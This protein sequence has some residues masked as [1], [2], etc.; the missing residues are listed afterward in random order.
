MPRPAHFGLVA[1]I[2]S[3]SATQFI[4][5]PPNLDPLARMPLWQAG[6]DF[7]HGT[8]HGVGS[9]L[10]VV[11]HRLPLGL[12]TIT[13]GSFCPH[14]QEP[15]HPEAT[16]CPHCRRSI[17]EVLETEAVATEPAAIEAGATT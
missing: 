6:L 11:V 8:G 2:S 3:P 9:Y 7:D 15:R 4:A 14:C 10:N 17:G 5:I 16:A 12:S 1:V 13:P